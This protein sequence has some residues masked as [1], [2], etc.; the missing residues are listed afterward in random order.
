MKLLI[1]GALGHIGSY[2]INDLARIKK[3]KK[4]YL[5]DNLSNE[6]FNVLFSIKNKKVY[7]KLMLQISQ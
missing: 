7:Q 2:V 5:I 6:R 4:I 1:T 3:I